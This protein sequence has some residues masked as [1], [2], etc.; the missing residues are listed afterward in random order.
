MIFM[1]R[2][3]VQ[4]LVQ[5]QAACVAYRYRFV[6]SRDGAPTLVPMASR[7]DLCNICGTVEPLERRAVRKGVEAG[8]ARGR[9]GFAARNRED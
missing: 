7:R 2:D 9:R 8:A 4:A 6:E 3:P 5:R 1:V